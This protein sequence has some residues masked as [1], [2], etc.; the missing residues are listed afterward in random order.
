[1]FCRTRGSA[2]PS[3]NPGLD[4]GTAFG[5]LRRWQMEIDFDERN[6]R[7]VEHNDWL[8]EFEADL[9][10]S[11]EAGYPVLRLVRVATLA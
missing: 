2:R 4:D 8:A 6:D 11:K 5:V 10:A 3:R 1:M 7:V 9:G